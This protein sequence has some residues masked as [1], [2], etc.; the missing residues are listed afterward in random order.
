MLVFGNSLD[1]DQMRCKSRWSVSTLSWGIQRFSTMC[2]SLQL[3]TLMTGQ[4]SRS[5]F[6]T[7]ANCQGTPILQYRWINFCLS[8]R[9]QNR[10][11]YL[12]AKLKK[13]QISTAMY[14]ANTTRE[15]G[16]SR[17][18]YYLEMPHPCLYAAQHHLLFPAR[19]MH[20]P[21]FGQRF[22]LVP[23]TIQGEI[24]GPQIALVM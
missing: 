13:R 2:S 10:G 11:L 20:L 22:I 3:I 16:G 18:R 1:V 17:S 21:S 8:T 5:R 7:C 15:I 9:Q 12:I 19:G 14:M 23:S 24:K 4:P 6:L